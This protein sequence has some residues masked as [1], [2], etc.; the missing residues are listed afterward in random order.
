MYQFSVVCHA[1]IYS[2]YLQLWRWDV[3]EDVKLFIV[4]QQSGIETEEGTFHIVSFTKLSITY[5]F[6]R[7]TYSF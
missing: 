7:N 3:Y 4:Q 1:F 2:Y 6:L 5:F